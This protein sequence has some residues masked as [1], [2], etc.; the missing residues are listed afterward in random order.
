MVMQLKSRS[1]ADGAPIPSE[2]AFAA[3]HPGTHI[4]LSANRNPHLAW[5]DVPDG[6]KSFVLIG[7]DYDVPS[8]GD[9]VNQENREVPAS[10]PRVEFFHWVLIDIPKTARAIEAGSHSDGVTPRGKSGPGAPYG[11]RHGMNDYTSWF[12]NDPDMRGDYYGYD[13]PC[14]PW[15]DSIIHHYSFT[16]HAIDLSRLEIH[17]DV[18]GHSASAALAGHVLATA[19]LTGTYSLNPRLR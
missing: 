16:L 6:T 14:P 1:F 19:V 8:K 18:D 9:D 3:I 12:A 11:L 5:T 7:H 13:G 17:G 15:N 10:L 2:F 4:A